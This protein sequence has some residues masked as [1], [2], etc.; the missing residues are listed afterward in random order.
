M[1][2]LI[3]IIGMDVYVMICDIFV[4]MCLED[5][6]YILYNYTKYFS[7]ARIYIESPFNAIMYSQYINIMFYMWYIL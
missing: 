6:F 4:Q 1:Y 7:Y 3:H 5:N 2:Q